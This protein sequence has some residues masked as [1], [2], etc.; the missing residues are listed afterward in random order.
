MSPAPAPA[1]RRRAKGVGRPPT[2]IAMGLAG[3]TPRLGPERRANPD[4]HVDEAATT[5]PAPSGGALGTGTNGKPAC[6]ASALRG[7]AGWHPRNPTQ[8]R[9]RDDRAGG[10]DEPRSETIARRSCRVVGRRD[11]P[12]RR[13]AGGSRPTARGARPVERG[14][15]R[16]SA[17]GAPSNT[18]SSPPT[19]GAEAVGLLAQTNGRQSSSSRRTAAASIW[20][21]GTFPK[22]G[23]RRDTDEPSAPL[24]TASVGPDD[25]LT[26]GRVRVSVSLLV[27]ALIVGAS[28]AVSLPA[29]RP[30]AP[31]PQT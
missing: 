21:A 2:R 28:V 24:T 10:S 4:H 20:L 22:N 3:A 31:R 29:G 11:R 14:R 19:L 23:R 5:G 25:S 9:R 18:A 13:R 27:I 7:S 15:A 8:G 30:S 16:P 6:A 17:S 26:M 1:A 12:T